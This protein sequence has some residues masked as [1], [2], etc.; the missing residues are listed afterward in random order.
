MLCMGVCSAGVEILKK[1]WH[2][3]TT[4][5]QGKCCSGPKD[6]IN[7]SIDPGRVYGESGEM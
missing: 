7:D 4:K 5:V 6:S 1:K 2:K 3:N